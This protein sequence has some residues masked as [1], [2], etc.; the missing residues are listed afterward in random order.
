MLTLLVSAGL[1]MQLRA[2]TVSQNEFWVSAVPTG[3]TA[4]AGTITDPYDGSTQV[5]FDALFNNNSFPHLPANC[6]VHLLGGTYMTSGAAGFVLQTGQKIL[7]SGMDITTVVLASGTGQESIFV[8]TGGDGIEICDLTC[9]ANAQNLGIGNYSAI[10]IAGSG[11]K[12][13]RVKAKGLGVGDI[14]QAVGGIRVD[15]LNA[16]D[17]V[18]EDCVVMP[19]LRGTACTSIVVNGHDAA[20]RTSAR[21]SGNWVYGTNTTSVTGFAVNHNYNTLLSGNHVVNA[22]YAVYADAGGNTNLTVVNNHFNNVTNGV[23]LAGSEIHQHLKFTG[24]IIELAYA[25]N[26]VIGFSL[27]NAVDAKLMGNTIS[28]Y[29]NAGPYLRAVDA[30][31]TTGALIADNSIDSRFDFN[32]TGAVNVNMH[33]NVDLS[34]NFL[35][36]TNQIE[37]P[38]SLTRKTVTTSP[39][40]AQYADRYIGVQAAGGA[41]ISLP[42][43]TGMQGKEFIIVNETG[44]GTVNINSPYAPINDTDH[45]SFSGGYTSKT[46]TTDGDAWYAR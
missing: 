12:I 18:I 28:T 25:A 11:T 20:S 42:N 39:Y 26:Q 19:P 22:A 31:T 32:L 9:D 8:C 7:G 27:G 13:R 14:T 3:T 1:R 23:Y 21:V 45:V 38:N 16:E 30:S 43:P 15:G 34:G 6:T 10:W 40:F 44:S 33:D 46:V 29:V 5:K 24:N 37:F 4:H 2:A 41:S 35:T 36:S 17:V